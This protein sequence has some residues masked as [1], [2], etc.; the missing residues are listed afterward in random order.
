MIVSLSKMQE[1]GGDRF[2]DKP[3]EIASNRRKHTLPAGEWD[4]DSRVESGV[5]QATREDCLC[6]HGRQKLHE[7]WTILS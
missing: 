7:R 4:P 6:S 3:N 5:N 2:G 1:A